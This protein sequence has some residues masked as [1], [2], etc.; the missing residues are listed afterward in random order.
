[1][2]TSPA[3]YKRAL[4][5]F[6]VVFLPIRKDH[7]HIILW[8]SRADLRTKGSEMGKAESGLGCWVD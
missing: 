4:F 1:M 7:K 3:T 5:Y 2:E 6:V 8:M